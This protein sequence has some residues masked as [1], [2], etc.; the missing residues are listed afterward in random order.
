[1]KV[2]KISGTQFVFLIV[3]FELGSAS[4]LDV[5]SPAK[6]DAWIVLLISAL[7]GMV[8]YLT[9]V[10]LFNKYP[11]VPLTGYVR[12]IWGKYLG[13]I[14]G[15]I[16]I[17][18][19]MYIASR[20]LRDFSEL[21]MVSAYVQES[22]FI[23][24]LCMVIVIMYGVYKG[25]EAFVRSIGI[26]VFMYLMILYC[27]ITVEVI[28]GIISLDNIKPILG[29]GLMPVF[30][31]IFPKT[32]TVPFGEMI[33]FTMLLPYLQNKNQAGKVGLIGILVSGILL[34]ND[35][36]RHMAIVGIDVEQRA[37]FPVLTTASYINYAGF[38]QRLESLVIILMIILGFVKISVFFFCAIIGISDLFR[39]QTPNTLIYPIGIIILIS[40]LVIAPNHESHIQE[41]LKIVPLYLHV[42][43]QIII[44]FL[45]L[46]TAIIR[47]K[48]VSR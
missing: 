27:I 25:F 17:M 46:L 24:G 6:Q 43:L 5:A 32:L 35:A 38:L 30:K 15:F 28:S 23:L 22:T 44:P 41:G 31:Q 42:P 11:T 37:I 10:A 3:M 4:L 21:L 18:Y 1:M 2:I 20:L 14:V 39:V 29:D 45:L 16:Y 12:Q 36:L 34:A 33:T 13:W 8:N 9:Y 47:K 48:L 19:F 26:I 40:S 7:L